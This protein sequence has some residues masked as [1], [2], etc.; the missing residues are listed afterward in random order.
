MMKGTKRWAAFLL[1]MIM[2][3]C[4]ASIM[5]TSVNAAECSAIT[6]GAVYSFKNAN[7]GKYLNVHYGYDANLTNVYQFDSDGSVEQTFRVVY[8]S[9]LDAYRIYAMCS[10]NG[11]SR[12]LDIYETSGLSSG[13]NVQIYNKNNVT[14]DQTF[15]FY[16]VGN[17]KY[18]IVMASNTNLALT[19]QGTS[20][21][22]GVGKSS[23]SA[24]NVYISTYSSSNLSQ[25][26]YIESAADNHEDYYN[27]LGWSYM[28]HGS[29]PPKYISSDYGY[30]TSP[31]TGNYTFHSGIDIPA[32]PGTEI[33]NVA[34]G[35]VVAKINE[36]STTTGRGYGIIIEHDDT[37][38]GSTTKLRTL[39]QHLKQASSLSVST[40]TI[41]TNVVVGLAGSTGASTGTHLHFTVI[42]D[43]GT[44][45]SSAASTLEP[46]FF[47]M[48][49]T[50][51]Y[52]T[53]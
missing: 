13:C 49:E 1:A 16:S 2:A 19:A 52:D 17:N 36:P 33:Y 10:S 45:S 7:S 28:F 20:N 5:T 41:G 3:L 50:F 42:K 53:Y 43:G 26:W 25:Q 35:R 38:Y 51:T 23:T 24:G 31:T 37:V 27:D 11:K 12:V 39:Y 9:D 44:S 48:D 46:M 21:G 8:D 29:N 30:R 32:T 22:T 18:K 40:Q 34:S 4:S 6:S 47:F 15:K 14:S